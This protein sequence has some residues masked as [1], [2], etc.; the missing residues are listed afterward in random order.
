M[1]WDVTAAMVLTLSSAICQTNVL[2][3][4]KFVMRNMT[5]IFKRTKGMRNIIFN[6][7]KN[8]NLTCS[9]RFLNPYFEDLNV[10]GCRNL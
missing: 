1:K 3:K 5:A 10:Y 4:A 2:T 6:G 8:K 9:F 7:K